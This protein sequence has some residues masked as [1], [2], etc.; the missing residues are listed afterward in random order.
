MAGVLRRLEPDPP[1]LLPLSVSLFC[2]PFAVVFCGRGSWVEAVLHVWVFPL[3][4]SDDNAL[5][6]PVFVQEPSPVM[7][8]LDSEEKKVKLTC[9]VK[10]N[11]K[12]HIRFV[13]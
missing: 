3:L 7:F 1:A 10:G 8:P 5:H 12:P 2:V 9:K 4:V 11:P 6:G 13:D